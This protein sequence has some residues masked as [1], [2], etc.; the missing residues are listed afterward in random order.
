MMKRTES[1][2][3][4]ILALDGSITP[5]MAEKAVRIL[6]GEISVT[7]PD[8]VDRIRAE[9]DEPMTAAEVADALGVTRRTVFTYAANGLIRRIGDRRKG[10]MTRFSRKSVEAFLKGE[11]AA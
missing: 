7:P 9:V 6:N 1:A 10:T 4:S 8:V 3:K 11:V 5:K 2:I